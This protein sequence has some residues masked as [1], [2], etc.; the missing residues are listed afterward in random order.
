MMTLPRF[1]TVRQE[2][3]RAPLGDVAGAT[4]EELRRIGLGARVRPGARIA[5]GAGSRGIAS[6]AV[7]VRAVVD[8]LRAMGAEPFIFP[9]M[10]SHGGA[11]AEGQREVL[12]EQGITP[13]TMGCPVVSSMAVVQMGAT[14]EGVPVF[15]DAAAHASDG[16]IVVN[17]VKIHTDFHG[18]TESGLTKM[19]VI[20]LGKRAGAEPIHQYGTRGLRE[21]IPQAALVQLAHAPV[22][23]GVAIIEDGGHS[24]SVVRA[25]P[26]AA[27]PAEEPGLLARSRELLPRL[28]LPTLDVLIVDRMGKDISGAGLD[29]NV[30][31][32][33]YIDGEAEPEEPRIGTIV[34]LRLT[35]AT[36]GNA[37]GTGFVDIVTED[38]LRAM[39]VEVTR[40]NI[41]TSGFLRR[42]RIPPAYPT[43]QAA[44][45]AAFARH[46]RGSDTSGVTAL[47][48]RD[49]LSLEEFEASES[50]LPALLDRPGITLVRPP[51]E[52]PFHADGRLL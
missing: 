37:C 19:L 47:H 41:E 11:T 27:I 46:A 45:E 21:I 8:E 13:E 48:I 38:L 22:L 10:G 42:G 5:V 1:A 31:G 3:P 51:R 15:C 17:R 16:I 7:V 29:N 35:E 4:R 30:L 14:A 36:H 6:Y 20:G 43:D 50:A 39:D 23:C 9:A 24:V 26:A 44:I 32:R 40:I 12:Q 49:T 52:L 18:P 2:V 25:V 33:M 28:P 34:T